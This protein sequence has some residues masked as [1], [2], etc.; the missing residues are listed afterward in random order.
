MIRS[1][2]SRSRRPRPGVAVGIGVLVI[3]SATGAYAAIPGGD[4]QVKGCYAL[5]N[6]LLLGIPYS[7]GDNRIVD[8]AESCRSYEK[9]IKWGLVGPKGD[10]GAQGIQGVKGETGATGAQGL[11]GDTGVPGPQGVKGDTGAIGPRGPEGVPGPMGAPGAIGPAGPAGPQGPAG[12]AVSGLGT[13]TNMASAGRGGDCTIGEI[14]LNAGSV[15]NGTPANGQLLPISQN[16]ALFSLLGT[17]YG[18]DG[19][20]TFA[21]PDLRSVAPNKMTYSIC[22]NGIYPVRS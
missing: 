10:T 22:I 7:K 5:T 20:T 11:K 21:L 6:G 18:G 17:T 4:G 19:V 15:A 8:E 2:V 3:A 9:A 13:D 1:V 12:P 14:I 16:T